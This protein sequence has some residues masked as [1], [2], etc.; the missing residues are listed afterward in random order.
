[1]TAQWK[2]RTA[3]M[4][5]MAGIVLVA[6]AAM[7]MMT[8]SEADDAKKAAQP[9]PTREVAIMARILEKK[10]GDELQG[11]VLTENMFQRGVQ[12]FH[13][14]GVGALFF[15]DVKFA[16]AAPPTTGTKQRTGDP[17]DLWNIYE[18][19]LTGKAGP[20]ASYV[21]T[22][23]APWRASTGGV[24]AFVF[25]AEHRLDQGK[26]DRLDK[27]VFEVL[28]DYGRRMKSLGPNDRIIVLVNGGDRTS[29]HAIRTHYIKTDSTKGLPED[30]HVEFDE[31]VSET[32]QPHVKAYV[33][34]GD[35]ERVK[36]AKKST[37]VTM[38][39]GPR[40]SYVLTSRLGGGT[41]SV[42]V[43]QIARKDLLDD[44]KRLAKVADVV[45]Y[46]Y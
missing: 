5:A 19:E 20:N 28:A 3:W 26:I 24:E 2:K 9:N 45:A 14:P 22:T 44:P 10:L 32:G 38:V 46:C 16:V 25:S 27:T 7:A 29:R 6:G 21:E 8:E 41:R 34:E 1:M 31:V 40:G 4:G 30:V 37:G 15:V 42:R 12:G 13:V 43:I 18:N 33:V 17:D 35:K 11:D 23:A 36:A 39:T